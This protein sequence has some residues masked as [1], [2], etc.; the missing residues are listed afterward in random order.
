MSTLLRLFVKNHPD[1]CPTFEVTAAP[2]ILQYLFPQKTHPGCEPCP[3]AIKLIP[4]S[5]QERVADLSSVLNT[6]QL[7]PNEDHYMLLPS[8]HRVR[9]IL[10]TQP[11]LYPPPSAHPI[12]LRLPRDSSPFSPLEQDPDLSLLPGYRR[13]WIHPTDVAEYFNEMGYRYIGSHV[14][15]CGNMGEICDIHTYVGGEKLK[16]LFGMLTPPHEA[17]EESLGTPISAAQ[18]GFSNY[19][20]QDELHILVLNV[21]RD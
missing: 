8:A 6:R 9:A 3:F 21:S 18:F 7:K 4:T 19:C 16:A 1:G 14:E 15:S 5:T 20:E 17:M 12:H 2:E 13:I 11:A 10:A